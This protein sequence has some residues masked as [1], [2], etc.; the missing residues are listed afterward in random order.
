[1]FFKFK[2]SVI[3]LIAVFICFMPIAQ[4]NE[5]FDPFSNIRNT[6][7][8]KQLLDLATNAEFDVELAQ[9]QLAAFTNTGVGK[10]SVEYQ[11]AEIFAYISINHV[12]SN[13]D[14]VK[15]YLE[16]LHLL[17]VK[18]GNDW[19]LGRYFEQQSVL[20]LRQGHFLK[21]MEDANRAIEIA[22]GLNYQESKANATSVRA[23]LHGRMGQGV[24]ALKDYRFA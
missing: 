17:G 11:V 21:G 3:A 6:P 14:E 16:Q 12:L 24:D 20:A 10:L 1:M 5:Y 23:I 13:F 7:Q 15:R 2:N 9:Q 8:G 19:V 4:A 18:K 22:D